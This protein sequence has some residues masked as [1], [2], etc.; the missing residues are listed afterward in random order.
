MIAVVVQTHVSHFPNPITLSKGDLVQIGCR[1]EGPEGWDNW[2]YCKRCSPDQE[3]W[4]PEQIIQTKDE[5]GIIL[6]N[7]CANELN[8]KP[9][10]RLIGLRELNG[11]LWCQHETTEELGWVPLA[12]ID[13]ISK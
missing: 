5:T 7:Y 9:G 10:E 8:V 2:L 4:V 6:E 12:N 1:Y 11:W 3:G 13:K